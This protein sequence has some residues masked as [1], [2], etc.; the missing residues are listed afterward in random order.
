M[1]FNATVKWLNATVN[2]LACDKN[3]YYGTLSKHDANLRAPGGLRV[4]LQ[5]N[6]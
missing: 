4:A 6:L 3:R 1:K 5:R 2:W